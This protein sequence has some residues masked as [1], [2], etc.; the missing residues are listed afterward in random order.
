V[1]HTKVDGGVHPQRREVGT[2]DEGSSDSNP[3][4]PPDHLRL[5]SGVD[6]VHGGGECQDMTEG[7]HHCK[8]VSEIVKRKKVEECNLSMS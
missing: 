6:A 1:E 3:V 8:L 4:I 5:P 7:D 2:V